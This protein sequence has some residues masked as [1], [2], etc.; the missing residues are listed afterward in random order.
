M[1]LSSSGG[2]NVIGTPQISSTPS[3]SPS[4]QYNI[5]SGN[6]GNGIT[7]GPDANRDS[8]VNNWIGLNIQGL[9]VLPNTGMAIQDDGTSNL[10]YG[11]AGVVIVGSG[12]SAT[13]LVVTA[14][15]VSLGEMKYSKATSNPIQMVVAVAGDAD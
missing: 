7:L 4:D 15:I 5:I 12:Q 14:P 8:I 6:N 3:P 9:L 2:G 1:L 13:G 10:I 11:N